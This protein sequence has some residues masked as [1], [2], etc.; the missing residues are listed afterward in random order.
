MR[1]SLWTRFADLLPEKKS[2]FDRLIVDTFIYKSAF[3]KNDPSLVLTTLKKYGIEGIELLIPPKLNNNDIYKVNLML[4]KLKIQVFSIHQS[5]TN[6][7]RIDIKE[8]ERLF[9]I[10][11]KFSAKVITI[12]ADVIG[13]KIYDKKYVNNFKLLEKKYNI[14]IGIENMPKSPLSLFKTYTYKGDEFSST[15]KKSGCKITLDTTHLAQTGS[16]IVSFYKNN[17]KQ[18]VNI[19]LSD[20]KKHFLN[21]N[22]LLTH[23]THLPLGKG[24]LPIKQFLQTLKENNY[25]GLLTMEINGT[26]ETLCQSARFMVYCC[27]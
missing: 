4:R 6:F 5:L 2:V 18:I 10:A 11:N 14:E 9:E 25:N 24:E 23:N 16:D 8:L 7:L 15:I 19:H 1:L 3:D 20:Y 26:L 17:K 22:L 27:Q 13:N 12:H 21:T